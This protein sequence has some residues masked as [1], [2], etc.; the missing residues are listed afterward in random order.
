MKKMRQQKI[1]GFSAAFMCFLWI[2]LLNIRQIQP[3]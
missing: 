3:H 1:K 2:Q